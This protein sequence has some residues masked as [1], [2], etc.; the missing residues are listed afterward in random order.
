MSRCSHNLTGAS[1]LS[2]CFTYMVSAISGSSAPSSRSRAKCLTRKPAVEPEVSFGD[3]FLFWVP[4]QPALPF[5]EQLLN[6]ILYNGL[7]LFG[8]EGRYQNVDVRQDV[9]Q[10]RSAAK[11][12]CIVRSFSPTLETAPSRM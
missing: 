8:V 1:I 2:S 9:L 6:L 7:M 12:H 10:P 4:G 5:S 3:C 11:S